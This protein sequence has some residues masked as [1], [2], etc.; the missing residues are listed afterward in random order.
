MRLS[1]LFRAA[2]LLW[3]ALFFSASVRAAD[4]RTVDAGEGFPRAVVIEGHIRSGDYEAFLGAVK[5]GEGRVS[6]VYVFSPGGS[7]VEAMKIG[8]AMRRLELTS[9]APAMSPSHRPRC[10][11]PSGTGPVPDDPKN[12]TCAS[13][14]FF[15]YIG[16]VKR[17]GD[18]L[19]V[20]CPYYPE[21][22]HEQRSPERVRS[23]EALL[24]EASL[25]YM[26]RMHV[27]SS[28]IDQVFS[29]SPDHLRLL[30]PASVRALHSRADSD[31]VS[32]A[33]ASEVAME[34]RRKAAFRTFFGRS[35]DS[36]RR[37]GFAE[38]EHAAGYLGRG[39]DELLANEPFAES[40][41]PEASVLTRMM[42]GSATVVTLR[43]DST[44][45]R[46]VV[47]VQVVSRPD[48]RRGFS[49]DLIA[50][51]SRSWGAPSVV[52]GKEEWV[53]SRPDFRAV[54]FYEGVSSRG[55]R[56]VLAIHAS[57]R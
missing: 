25:R 4:I 50:A 48:P 52:Y 40:R 10:G 34:E 11:G 33:A 23:A 13:A 22:F 45:P 51:L 19:A 1:F 21:S 38:W 30:D 15:V 27:P 17:E 7:V 32:G 8:M 26:T 57:R 16:G 55:A 47:S 37:Q 20:H 3:T 18:F 12:C 53:W 43:D 2:P 41:E 39:Y 36:L 35:A 49:R 31:R 6:R 56:F 24:H 54:L 44:S 5:A 14:A 28:I 46:R 9:V 42:P 29:T